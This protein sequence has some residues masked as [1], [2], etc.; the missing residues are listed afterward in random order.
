MS[1]WAKLFGAPDSPYEFPLDGVEPG[2][3]YQVPP[4]YPNAKVDAVEILYPR[5]IVIQR[6]D[7]TATAEERDKKERIRVFRIVVEAESGEEIELQRFAAPIEE[8]EKAAVDMTRCAGCENRIPHESQAVVI[9]GKAYHTR[10]VD[11]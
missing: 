3:R 5:R 1:E 8:L 6:I 9:D 4:P 11:E 7:L 10:C 2:S